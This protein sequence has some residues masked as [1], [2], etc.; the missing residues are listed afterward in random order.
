MA[1]NAAKEIKISMKPLNLSHKNF[2]IGDKTIKIIKSFKNQ[3]WYTNGVFEP[4][5][6]LW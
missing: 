3:N 4:V 2:K 6:K 1:F 5:D